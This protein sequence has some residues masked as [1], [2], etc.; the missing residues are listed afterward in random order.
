MDTAELD[1]VLRSTL[2]DLSLSRSER[3]ALNEVFGDVV[4][5]ANDAAFLRN[6]AFALARQHLE[7][8]DNGLVLDW[9]EEVVKVVAAAGGGPAVGVR[10]EACFTPEDRCPDRVAE[11]FDQTAR[12]ADACVFTIT[13]DRIS[14]A[15]LRA[16]QR[17]VAVRII[18]DDDKAADPG[19][20]VERLARA[21]V[22]VR[23]DNSPYHMHHKF[24]L[25]DRKALLT[26]SYNWT[27][28][29]AEH[30]EENFIITSE[31]RL[32]EA[33]ADK[34]DRMWERFGQ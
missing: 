15:I 24:A 30:N 20:D 7:G 17:G 29:A 31:P 16:H 19:S 28:G 3:R 5:Q 33:F 21:G 18:T 34:F 4:R 10:G 2:E 27:R 25:F 8:R 32:I 23:T 1:A 14:K 12:A 9:L 11:L 6:R 26:G 13:D 22:A